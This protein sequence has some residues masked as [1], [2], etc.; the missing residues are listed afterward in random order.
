MKKFM[1]ILLLLILLGGAGFFFGWAQFPLALGAYGVM[2]SKTHGTDPEVIKGGE[3]RWVWYKLI[4]TNVEILSFTLPKIS[5]SIENRGSLPSGQV[6]AALA[7]MA[8]DFG[9]QVE[10]SL[11]FTLKPESLPSLVERE[12]IS[13]Q[14]E[15]G[16]YTGI[17]G[18]RIESFIVDRLRSYGE[19]GKLEKLLESGGSG[20]LDA[21]IE[22]AFP[23]AG[24]ISWGIKTVRFPD[25]ALYYSLKALY[26]DYLERQRASLKPGMEETAER[27]ISSRLRFDELEK[28]GKLLTQYPVL[29]RYLALEKGFP[30]GE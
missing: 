5:R 28:Y 27:Q 13:G 1:G 24:D 3:F 23:Q 11:S 29:L 26:D 15:L 8:V 25:F 30:P 10:G 17:L 2:R 20:N 6:Y 18:D 7:G 9:W 21:G 22:N 12:H 16:I 14:E 19:E 4:P